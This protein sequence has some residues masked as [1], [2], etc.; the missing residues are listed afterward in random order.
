MNDA[1]NTVV[2]APSDHGL[3]IISPAA[4]TISSNSNNNNNMFL[5]VEDVNSFEDKE[6]DIMS[7]SQ[8]YSFLD[9]E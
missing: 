6:N 4:V 1:G 8:L 5:S 7:Q 2:H 3:Q 9:N